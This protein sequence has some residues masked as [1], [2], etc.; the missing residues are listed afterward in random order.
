ME[1]KTTPCQ[2]RIVSSHDCSR[3]GLDVTLT[4]AASPDEEKSHGFF[5]INHGVFAL[6]RGHVLAPG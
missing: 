1:E 6:A 2:C 4:E 5:R 3:H